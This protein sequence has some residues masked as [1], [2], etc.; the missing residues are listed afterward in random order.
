MAGTP[1]GA[2]GGATLSQALGL[3]A[4]NYLVQHKVLSLGHSY[5]VMDANKT[6][7]FHVQGDAGQNLTGSLLG[8][9]VGGYLGR[10][11]ARSVDMTYGIVATSGVRWGTLK[12]TGG[13][14]QSTFTL[15]DNANQPWVII[16]L[17]RSLIG[18]IQATAVW[19]NGQPMMHTKG[20]LLR[21]NFFIKD[22]A[23]NDL[24]KVH[25]QWIALRDTY[26]VDVLGNIDPLYPLVYSIAIDYE[27]VK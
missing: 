4:R 22:P 12:K 20:N 24:A 16:Q 10:M 18:G 6:E 8:S 5:R 9:A 25:E 26:N 21:H 17:Q 19:P 1:Q 13:A 15:V 7:L 3:T 11:V 27:K 14:N 23:G 2:Q